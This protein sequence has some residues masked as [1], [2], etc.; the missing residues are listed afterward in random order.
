MLNMLRFIPTLT[1]LI[2]N[3]LYRICLKLKI[4]NHRN[5]SFEVK[6]KSE[7]NNRLRVSLDQ[8]PIIYE[9]IQTNVNAL[10]NSTNKIFQC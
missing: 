1:R 5:K 10:F 9:A 4:E 3:D 6:R 8:F 7:N 2:N